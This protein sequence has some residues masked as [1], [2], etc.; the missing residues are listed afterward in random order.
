MTS[1]KAFY[2]DETCSI[3]VIAVN[4]IND[5]RHECERII[6]YLKIE[7][8][9]NRALNIRL[10]LGND[11]SSFKYI[12]LH[13]LCAYNIGALWYTLGERFTTDSDE[14]SKLLIFNSR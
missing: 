1:V 7:R 2:T 12:R 10:K 5:Y 14:I 3:L 9:V 13:N 8:D 4:I 11:L 6:R